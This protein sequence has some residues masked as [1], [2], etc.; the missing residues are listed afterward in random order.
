MGD[1]VCL[2]KVLV[3]ND[4]TG[5]NVVEHGFI[6]ANSFT[7]AVKHLEDHL[8]GDQLLEIQHMELFD[9]C[10]IVS[11]STWEGMKKELTEGV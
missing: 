2:F 10:P 8:Y 9:C 3:Y 1:Y 6:F 7:H 4:V 11:A 5:E